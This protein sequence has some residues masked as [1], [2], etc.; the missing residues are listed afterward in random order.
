[1]PAYV[2]SEVE[3]L[4]EAAAKRYMELAESSITAYN[5]QYLA[6]GVNP[7]VVEGEPTKRR[8]VMVK[9]PSLKRAHE[10][11]ESSAYAKALQFRGQAL[12]RRL[13]FVDGIS[14]FSSK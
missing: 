1:M 13:M 3:I 10:W 2:I 5:G 6:R 9:F 12:D 7:E 14:L 4:N 11:Y 8:F